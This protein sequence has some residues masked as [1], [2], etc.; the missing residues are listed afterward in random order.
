MSAVLQVVLI[1]A[2]IAFVVLVGCV[3]PVVL[4]ARRQIERAVR[5]V[6]QLSADTQMLVQ[7]SREM[8]RSVNELSRQASQQAAEVGQ[9]VQTVRQWTERAD[10]FVNQVGSVIEP[11]MSSFL[12]GM[13]LLRTGASVYMRT[14]A[15][16]RQSKGTVETEAHREEQ[17]HV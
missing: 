14:L 12:Q 16:R 1:L 11:P 9:V 13:N 3:I 10:R 7:D 4:H 5:S 15:H 8:V 6:E 17:E 2:L